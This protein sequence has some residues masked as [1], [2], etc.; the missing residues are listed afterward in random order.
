M[1]RLTLRSSEDGQYLA[2]VIDQGFS[3]FVLDF[4]EPGV[5]ADIAQRLQHGFTMFRWG[6]VVQVP[7]RDPEMLLLLAEHYAAQG[8][9]VFVDEPNWPGRERTLEDRLQDPLEI[10]EDDETEEIW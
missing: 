1:L 10:G 7:A 8:L 5:I 2:R 4:G 9:L 6:R 3:P